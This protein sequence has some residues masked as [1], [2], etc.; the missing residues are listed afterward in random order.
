MNKC[1]FIGRLAS[2]PIVTT[3][4][5][6]TKV[7]LDLAL[8]RRFKK[9]NEELSYHTDFIKCEAWDSGAEVISKSF[10]N[11]DLIIVQAAARSQ[12]GDVVF[13]ITEFSFPSSCGL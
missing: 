7:T 1:H 6:T 2:D 13:R 5:N 10:R 12:G 9:N 8:T 4:Q 11:G 3:E